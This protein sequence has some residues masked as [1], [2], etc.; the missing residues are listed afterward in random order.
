MSR[1]FNEATRVQMPAMVH[2]CRLG[3]QFYGKMHLSS[4]GDKYDGQTNILLDI[5]RKQFG[6]QTR[7]RR[8]SQTDTH[9]DLTI[10]EKAA[11]QSLFLFFICIYEK[12]VTIS[13]R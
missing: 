12:K 9:I 4:G 11:P 13:S 6:E 8:I 10:S 5:F 2:L 7:I 3:Y 1:T